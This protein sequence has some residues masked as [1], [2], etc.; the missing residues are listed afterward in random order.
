M[1]GVGSGAGMGVYVE[2]SR[3]LSAQEGQHV[4]KRAMLEDVCVVGGMKAVSITEHLETPYYCDS[5][6][7]RMRQAIETLV[8]PS[9][10]LH[11]MVP[12]CL[13]VLA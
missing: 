8:Y 5:A 10:L 2:Q 4:Y 9:S 7:C 3:I 1:Q 13:T 6:S 11:V 12:Q